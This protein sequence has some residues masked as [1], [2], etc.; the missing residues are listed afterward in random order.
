MNVVADTEV[1][2]E[3]RADTAEWAACIAGAITRGQYRA[4]LAAAGFVDVEV[5]DSHPVQD[6]FWSVFV[7]ASKPTPA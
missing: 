1:D 6:G 4:V 3:L 5:A 7:R 2:P